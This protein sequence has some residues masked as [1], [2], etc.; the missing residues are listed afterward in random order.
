[1]AQ[2]DRTQQADGTAATL[3]GPV[4]DS[5]IQV[6]RCRAADGEPVWRWFDQRDRSHAYMAGLSEPLDGA[7][8]DGA[9]ADRLSESETTRPRVVYIHIPFCDEIC[10]FCA[11]YRQVSGNESI[12]ESYVR[13]LCR[14]IARFA[15]TP[16]A[17]A[18]PFD[19]IYFGGGTPTV[20]S[21][22]QLTRVLSHL[23]ALPLSSDGEITLETRCRRIDRDDLHTLREA[24]VNRLSVGVQSFDTAVRREARR[25][26]D[27]EEVL[28]ALSDAADAGL[29][30]LSIDLIYNL[31]GQ[32]LDSWTRTLAT[33]DQTPVSGCSV[34]G[35]IVQPKSI[36][37]R[38]VAAS[39]LALGDLQQEYRYHDA[40]AKYFR[41]RSEWRRLS[42]V[43]FGR[44][45]VETNVYNRVRGGSIDI[46][47]F[48]AG[49]AWRIGDL[50][51]MNLPGVQPFIDQERAAMAAPTRVSRTWPDAERF[52]DLFELIDGPGVSY[53]RLTE[54]LP[55]WRA[56]LAAL[57]EIGLIDHGS[58]WCELSDRGSFWAYNIGQAVQQA[59]RNELDHA[60]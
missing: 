25:L 7:A 5:P 32:T 16:W 37:G 41:G 34:Y 19:A 28:R 23:R 48:G 8:A 9:L 33:L 1:M 6:A 26:A 13:A 42:S 55:H 31:P 21:V 57:I 12:I 56:D 11:F 30:N 27:R 44:T 40:A 53:T 10:S 18:R 60:A 47:G 20:L 50:N 22:E 54:Q 49:A 51:C 46:L 58:D 36:L 3:G 35:L 39:G 24:G 59:I 4:E 43:H 45:G 29:S 14:Q 17:Q 38:Q 15:P 52:V 2:T